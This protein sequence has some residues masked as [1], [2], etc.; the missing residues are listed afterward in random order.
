MSFL[1]VYFIILLFFHSDLK[2]ENLSAESK[3]LL[4]GLN[5]EVPDAYLIQNHA[6]SKVKKSPDEIFKSAYS[7]IEKKTLEKLYSFFQ[8]DF[9]FFGYTVDIHNL[10]ISF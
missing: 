7:G 10:T 6:S 3:E 1:T 5:I 8:K 2:V 9:E 4:E